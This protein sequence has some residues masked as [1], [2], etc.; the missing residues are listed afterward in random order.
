MSFDMNNHCLMI[1]I[2]ICLMICIMSYDIYC[3]IEV[4]CTCRQKLLGFL[5][6]TCFVVLH[7]ISDKKPAR[8]FSPYKASWVFDEDLFLLYT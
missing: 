7:L 6:N 5:V 8:F 3:I 2:M 4:R 1:C